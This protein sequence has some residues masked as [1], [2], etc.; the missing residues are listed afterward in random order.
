MLNVLYAGEGKLKYCYNFLGVHCYMVTAEIPI[1]PG[2]QE[3]RMEVGYDGGGG[4]GSSGFSSTS[5]P[6]ATTI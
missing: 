2:A 5:A 4:G 1:P 6:S 3:V